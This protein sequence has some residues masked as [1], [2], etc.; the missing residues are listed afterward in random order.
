MLLAVFLLQLLILAG[1]GYHSISSGGKLEEKQALS[2][3]LG[4]TDLSIA[5]DC[6]STRN[7]S[8]M[9]ASGCFR[10]LPS[11]LCYH[12]SC[13]GYAPSRFIGYR[14]WIGVEK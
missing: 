7:P 10:D 3:A 12:A 5:T 4:L 2:T 6:Y 14:T 8:M 13:S 11:Q 1:I 9:D